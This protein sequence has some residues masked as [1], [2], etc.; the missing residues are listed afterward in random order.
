MEQ[1]KVRH[2]VLFKFKNDAPQ[3][4]V[5]KIEKAFVELK[6]QIDLIESIEWGTNVSPEGINQGFTHCFF[7]TFNSE[8]DRDAY[9][10]HPDHKAFGRLLEPFLEKVLVVDYLI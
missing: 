6:N 10:P 4:S 5:E 3:E 9:L 1:R 2:L 7:I 8:K